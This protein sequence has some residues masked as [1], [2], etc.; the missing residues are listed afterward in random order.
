MASVRNRLVTASMIFVFAVAFSA[1]SM[2]WADQPPDAG[3]PSPAGPGD[4]PEPAQVQTAPL[5]AN[6][7]HQN[8]LQDVVLGLA[9]ARAVESTDPQKARDILHKTKALLDASSLAE[10]V[11]AELAR[12]L[13]ERSSALSRSQ[14]P[15]LSGIDLD[16]P[17]GKPG[18]KKPVDTRS[19]DSTGSYTTRL[20]SREID[21]IRALNS[22]LKVKFEDMPL[23]DVFNLIEERT[24]GALTIMPDEDLASD[25]DKKRVFDE[26]VK[27]KSGKRMTIRTMLHK[28]LRD[29]NLDYYIED[30]ILIV[31][32]KDNAEKQLVS[33]FYP[34]SNLIPSPGEPSMSAHQ[35]D[36]RN[37]A[38]LAAILQSTVEPNYWR[39]NGGPGTMEFNALTR[40]L[41]ITA[42]EEVHYLLIASGLLNNVPRPLPKNAP[43]K[44]LEGLNVIPGTQDIVKV[45]DIAGLL[46]TKN[47]EKSKLELQLALN[48]VVA[49]QPAHKSS[50]DG[51]NGLDGL[52][53]RKPALSPSGGPAEG[54]L[55]Q[56][57]SGDISASPGDEPQP[58]E[59][60]PPAG[61]YPTPP[62]NSPFTVTPRPGMVN[63]NGGNTLLTTHSFVIISQRELLI[64]RQPLEVHQVIERMLTDMKAEIA[65]GHGSK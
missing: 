13:A 56:F 6:V 49:A 51:P 30:G 54:G 36:M 28:I 41:K 7:I 42:T 25:P 38:D 32:T 4:A 33:K 19:L 39:M 8:V 60:S 44:K 34:I 10:E 5:K 40:S 9:Q 46:D 48:M 17:P 11:R 47:L 14:L 50:G 21:L 29:K 53:E 52:F 12:Q 58:A 2:S 37:A 31:T 45:Y 62:M 63:R 35:A 64:A 43:A 3:N 55:L 1:A 57:P 18:E 24:K 26:P 65:K 22:T 15:D 20:S 23:K 27:F 61:P 16:Q 59:K